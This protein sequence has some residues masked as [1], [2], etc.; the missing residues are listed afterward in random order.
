MN[1]DTYGGAPLL[2]VNGNVLITHGSASDVA[3]ENAVGIAIQ[4]FQ[5]NINQMI[6]DQIRNLDQPNKAA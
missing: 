1:P 6:T 2:G 3:I 4:K 5:F